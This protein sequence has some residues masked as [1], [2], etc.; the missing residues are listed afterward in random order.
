MKISSGPLNKG[1]WTI[2]SQKAALSLFKAPLFKEYLFEAVRAFK[3]SEKKQ[4][5]R[6]THKQRFRGI[7]PGFGGWDLF[8]CFF[9]LHKER[10]PKKHINNFLLLCLLSRNI[11]WIFFS[12]LPG[13]FALKKGRDFWWI[14]SGLRFLGNEAR[15]FLKKFGE[16]SEQTSGGNSGQK[17]EKFG[18]LLFCHF[19][20]LTFWHPPSPGTIPQICLR[21][22]L[23]FLSLSRGDRK[24][25]HF[26]Q[27]KTPWVGW[28]C[29]DCPGFL[30]L[31]AAPASASTFVS[32]P[33]IL[34]LGWHFASWALGHL[35]GS[36]APYHWCKNRTHSTSFHSTGGHTPKTVT[37]QPPENN[38]KRGRHIRNSYLA[39][40]KTFQDGNGNG[41]FEEIN[42]NDFLDGNWESMEMKGRLRGSRR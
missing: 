6:K 16:F 5:K 22:F 42:S 29:A 36:A 26:Y 19:S 34:P 12:Y 23:F 1:I 8:M 31:S 37:C 40:S 25:S 15:K 17:S 2:S 30:V 28:A 9:L 24:E 11:L 7:V 4:T 14:F 18:E 13:N 27:G 35:L 41:N 20:D 33:Q 39:N 32:E 38:T 3:G 21:F 10:P